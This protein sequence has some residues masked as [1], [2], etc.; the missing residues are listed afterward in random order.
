MLLEETVS[1]SRAF[2]RL[3]TRCEKNAISQQQKQQQS[4][5]LTFMVNG[6]WF[7]SISVASA[8]KRNSGNGRTATAKRQRHDGNGRTAPELRKRNAGNQ[9]LGATTIILGSLESA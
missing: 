5:C 7:P 1:P 2:Q 8:R 9:A 6:K 4:L 3:I